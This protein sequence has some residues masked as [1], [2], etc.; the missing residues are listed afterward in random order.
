[1]DLNSVERLYDML[2]RCTNKFREAP[3]RPN[4]LKI[5]KAFCGE[6]TDKGALPD[7]VSKADS[8]SKLKFRI[9]SF[10]VGIVFEAFSGSNT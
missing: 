5:V 10:H 8:T 6:F 1:M 2:S 4:C 7:Q 9:N 3:S